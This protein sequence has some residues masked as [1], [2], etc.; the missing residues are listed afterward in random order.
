MTGGRIRF[1]PEP[2]TAA[3][4]PSLRG[5]LE[6]ASEPGHPDQ[7]RVWLHGDGSPAR[8]PRFILL[9]PADIRRLCAVLSRLTRPGAE[10][11]PR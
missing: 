3:I 11:G 4:P 8:P 1:D 2:I 5:Y 6:A 7:G 9:T 10:G